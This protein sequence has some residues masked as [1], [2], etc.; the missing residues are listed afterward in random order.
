M[1]CVYLI[2]IKV[3]FY[4]YFENSFPFVFPIYCGAFILVYMLLRRTAYQLNATRASLEP[5]FQYHFGRVCNGFPDSLSMLNACA[6]A[7]QFSFQ[8]SELIQNPA[9]AGCIALEKHAPAPYIYIGWHIRL[10][11][12]VMPD[13]NMHAGC[14]LYF[15]HWF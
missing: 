1:P 5:Q 6:R 4:T 13:K 12:Y 10:Y 14:T 15:E 9:F 8:C 11:R 2:A 3:S 7:L